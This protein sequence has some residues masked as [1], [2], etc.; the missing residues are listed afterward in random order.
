LR[1]NFPSKRAQREVVRLCFC[2]FGGWAPFQKGFWRR[3]K[4]VSAGR[5]GIEPSVRHWQ[6]QSKRRQLAPRISER[7][8]PSG[9]K[10]C[11]I[12]KSRVRPLAILT[13]IAL[14]GC[15]SMHPQQVGSL[16]DPYV[17]QPVSVIA[18]R[19]GP[20]SGHFASSAVETTYTWENFG[21][22]QSGMAGCRIL[23]VASRGAGQDVAAASQAYGTDPI[24]PEE[25]WKWTIKSWSSFGSGCR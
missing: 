14:A 15:S 2:L 24:S 6:H 21:A 1:T 25:F 8:N 22:G 23:V 13:C 18:D 3:V 9:G 4:F 5:I 12:R 17:G 11:P 20:P 10:T 19:F 16:L 7:D